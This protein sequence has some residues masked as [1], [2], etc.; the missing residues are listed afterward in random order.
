MDALAADVSR[1][2]CEV[3]IGK[4]VGVE[5]DGD[6][7]T[8]VKLLQA[9]AEKSLPCDSLILSMGCWARDA[10]EW[11]PGSAMPRDTVSNRYTSVIWDD[12]EIGKAAT[13][14]FVSDEHHVEIYPRAD[15]CYANGCPTNVELPDNPDDIVPPPQTI[16]DV[17]AETITAVERLKDAKVIR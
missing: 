16:E 6:K 10:A 5:L 8:A 7:V 14:V 2:G 12:T 4:A 3:I 17:K 1:A 9:G 13:M 15:E 11:F